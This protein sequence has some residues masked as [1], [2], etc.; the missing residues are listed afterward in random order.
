MTLGKTA[1]PSNMGRSGRRVQ[2]FQQFVV[3]D[4]ACGMKVG[5]DAL[6]LGAWA[7]FGEGLGRVREYF[8]GVWEEFEGS[9]DGCEW[10]C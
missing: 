2:Q 5:T 7:G 4:D 9:F 10:I 3:R 8:G 1:K 6:I